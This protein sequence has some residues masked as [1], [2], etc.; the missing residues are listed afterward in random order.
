VNEKG[1][2]VG[3]KL[4]K[5][6]ESMKQVLLITPMPK[7]RMTRYSK[8]S[9]KNQQYFKWV[10]ALQL[11]NPKTDWDNLEIDFFLPM[12]KSWSDSKKKEMD[13]KPHRQ[14]P[15][16]DNLL[17]AFKDALLKQDSFVWKYDRI[18]KLWGYEGLIKCSVVDL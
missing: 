7:P 12:P 14:T 6:V 3:I 8:W 16:L 17:K 10:N 13:G 11:L 1:F 2:R 18:I 9:K 5:P 15:D 4:L